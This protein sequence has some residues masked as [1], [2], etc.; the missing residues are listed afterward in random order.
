MSKSKTATARGNFKDLLSTD[1]KPNIQKVH[2]KKESQTEDQVQ[3]MVWITTE[4]MIKLKTKSVI[5]KKSMKEIVNE[6]L[7]KNL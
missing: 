2:Q 3:L 5:D 4:L 6:I 1:V 7:D